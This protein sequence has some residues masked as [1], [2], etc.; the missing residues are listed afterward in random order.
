MTTRDVKE[1][2]L[3]HKLSALRS[4]L[5]TFSSLFYGPQ[6]NCFGSISPLPSTL[7]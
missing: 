2:A 1:A 4:L 5:V 6:L 3:S 7:I